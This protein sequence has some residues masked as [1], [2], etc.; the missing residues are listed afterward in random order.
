MQWLIMHAEWP[1]WAAGIIPV[2]WGRLHGSV[3]KKKNIYI[4][5]YTHT[6]YRL[7]YLCPIKLINTLWSIT[8]TYSCRNTRGHCMLLHHFYRPIQKC[9]YHM[10][11][12]YDHIYDMEHNL[13]WGHFVWVQ[14]GQS[15]G[16]YTCWVREYPL[17]DVSPVQY[18]PNE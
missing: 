11:R 17:V 7:R 14:A 8:I 9:C 18:P 2:T 5:I 15:N 4:Y 1:S 16:N 12:L 10:L 13:I 3:Y 6:Q